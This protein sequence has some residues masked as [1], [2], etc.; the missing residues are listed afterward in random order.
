[1]AI[2]QTD[3]AE[4]EIFDGIK[5]VSCQNFEVCATYSFVKA[6]ETNFTDTSVSY[7]YL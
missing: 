3:L 2:N 7:L 1:M 5:T 6:Q 4:S